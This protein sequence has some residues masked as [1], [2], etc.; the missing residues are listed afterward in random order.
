M[1][2]G[3]DFFKAAFTK[4]F[5][6]CRRHH[7][8]VR[9]IK[10]IRQSQETHDSTIEL[11]DDPP[12][13]V[14]GLIAHF[15]GIDYNGKDDASNSI[16]SFF[17][18]IRRWTGDAVY[19]NYP[20][21]LYALTGK[22]QVPALREQLWYRIPAMAIVRGPDPTLSFM[23]PVVKHV[24]IHHADT[25]VEL[26]KPMVDLLLKQIDTLNDLPEFQQLLLDVPALS[27]ELVR[28]LVA[29]EKSTTETEG[30]PTKRPFNATAIPEPNI[31]SFGKRRLSSAASSEDLRTPPPKPSFTAATQTLV[32]GVSPRPAKFPRPPRDM[33]KPQSS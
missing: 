8:N 13:A 2:Q 7:S 9:F 12:K 30:V 25:A 3:S 32:P 1:A 23:L 21:D 28:A 27:A 24:Y 6:V 33:F 11:H 10:L 19:V 16:S 20:F 17:D 4:A 22:Y 5:K 15:Y 14:K 26:H 29:Q 31:F 18:Y